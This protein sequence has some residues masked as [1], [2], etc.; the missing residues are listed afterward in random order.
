MKSLVLLIVI[1]TACGDEPSDGLL[2]PP[3]SS[4]GMQLAMKITVQPGEEITVCK[5]FAMPEGAFDVGRFE[6]AMTPISHHLLVYSLSVPADHVTD[7]LIAQCDESADVQTTRVGI[8]FGSQSETTDVALPN[9]IAFPTRGGLAVQMEYHVVNASDEPVD[10]EAAL[11]LWRAKGPITGEAGVLFFYHTRIAIPPQSQAS[12]R[13]RWGI[14]GDVELMMIVPHMHRHATG[15]QAFRDTGDGT[16]SKLVDVQGWEVPNQVLD[17]PVHFA[18]NDILDFHCNYD[19][20]TSSYIFDGFSARN[21]EMC[22]AA[23]LYYRP[24]ADRLP[25]QDEYNFGGGIVYSGTNSCTQIQAC[26]EQIDWSAWSAPPLPDG[27]LDLCVLDGCQVGAD[28]FTKL[29]NCRMDQCGARCYASKDGQ[30]T[31]LKLGDQDCVACVETNCS[32]VRDA[33]ATATCP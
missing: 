28:T 6:A 21:N 10:A 23:S 31:G 8:L 2:K 16:R 33:C 1:V 9:Q 7:E 27:R 26:Q 30:I 29:D 11:N 22:V 12:A 3:D 13:M 15:M 18:K 5:N 20:P 17:P 24:N 19:N 4:E 32:A 25:L 14:P